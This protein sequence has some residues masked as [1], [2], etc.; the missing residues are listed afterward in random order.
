MK[1]KHRLTVIHGEILVLSSL[2]FSHL[3]L[4]RWMDII[5]GK[6]QQKK[7]KNYFLVTLGLGHMRSV[8]PVKLEKEKKKKRRRF[9]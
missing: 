3:H 5:D 1:K 4:N 6:K 2:Y 7:G 8:F 9:H